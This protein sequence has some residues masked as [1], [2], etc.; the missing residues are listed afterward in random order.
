MLNHRF[1]LLIAILPMASL[2]AEKHV[3][4]EAELFVALENGQ[5]LLELES[6]AD[7]ILGF[8]YTPKTQAQHK[9]LE[10]SLNTLNDYRH[11]ITF[12]RGACKQ[13]NANVESPFEEHHDENHSE[14]AKHEEHEEHEKHEEHEEH[15]KHEKHKEHE[16]HAKHEEH[17]EHHDHDESDDGHSGFHVSYTLQCDKSIQNTLT[18]TINAF[19]HFNGF[20]KIQVNWVTPNKQGSVLTTPAKTGVEME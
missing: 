18:A 8:E 20:E 3:H 7:N 2:A 12:D 4:G 15:A 11:L 14:H 6:P 5:I 10:S 19:K 17:E 16:E 9:Q 1:F 13:V